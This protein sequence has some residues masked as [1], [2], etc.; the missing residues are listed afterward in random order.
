MMR[1]GDYSSDGLSGGP[2]F[3]LGQDAQGFY[4]GF[5]SVILRGSESSD[6]IHFLD[7][8]LML[9]FPKRH[10]SETLKA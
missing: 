6:M 3:H 7:V 1:T 10:D 5:A 2:V 9:Q 4:C 8:R